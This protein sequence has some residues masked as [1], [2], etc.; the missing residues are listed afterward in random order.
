MEKKR[1]KNR[2]RDQKEE[3]TMQISD[4]NLGKK[5]EIHLFH[6]PSDVVVIAF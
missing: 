2:N 6:F 5:Y 3:I 4:K 1:K